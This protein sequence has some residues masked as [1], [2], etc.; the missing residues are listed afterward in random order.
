MGFIK[1]SALLKRL[2]R[3]NVHIE[4]KVHGEVI[5]Y[6]IFLKRPTAGIGPYHEYFG[7]ISAKAINEDLIKKYVSPKIVEYIKKHPYRYTGYVSIWIRELVQEESFMSL[8]EKEIAQDK[9]KLKNK[10]A[11][12]THFYPLH[13]LPRKYHGC[14]VGGHVLS[15]ILEDLKDKHKIKWAFTADVSDELAPIL[16]KVKGFIKKRNFY[17][18]RL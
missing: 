2:V 1:Y 17:A 15:F 18:R 9:L 10:I 6:L 13:G 5:Q 4:K 11:H 8:F 14:G 3:E 12:I 16:T 7:G